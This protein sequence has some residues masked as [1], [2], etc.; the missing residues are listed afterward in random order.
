[1]SIKAD[2]HM[3]SHHSGD[4]EAPM[5]EMIRAGIAAGLKTICFTEHNDFDYRPLND[6]IDHSFELN[7]DSYLYELLGLKKKY[8]GQIELL[9]GL[10]CGMQPELAKENARFV[11]EHEY[12]FVLASV[13]VC[14]GKDPYFPEF[15]E[16]KRE[17]EAL[18]EY[19]EETYINIRRFGNFDSLGHL[20]YMIRYCK[21]M[22]RQYEYEKYKDIIDKILMNLID[23]EKA[24][25]LN[26]AGLRKG[27]NQM[28]PNREVL[29]RYRALG[30]ELI[31]VG[32]DAHRPEDVAADFDRAEELLKSCGFH[33]YT[34]YN[35]RCAM[36]EKL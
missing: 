34:V 19:L 15:F 24:L 8:E 11:K 12:D 20:D 5:E 30:G 4:S 31:T 23:R 25:E 29:V 2:Y 10:E 1:M 18:R 33:Y 13:H 7:A 9:F 21:Q 26:T 14:N 36:M 22:D 17:E 28:H 27:M 35:G 32:S 3:H 16:G 6:E